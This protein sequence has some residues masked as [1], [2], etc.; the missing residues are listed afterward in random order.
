MRCDRYGLDYGKRFYKLFSK[1]ADPSAPVALVDGEILV[2]SNLADSH[3]INEDD[4]GEVFNNGI[5]AGRVQKRR[6]T[7]SHASIDSASLKRAK[8]SIDPALITLTA[9]IV[10]EDEKERNNIASDTLSQTKLI[11]S[12]EILHDP[13]TLTTN[14][15]P[16]LLPRLDES[17][18]RA[19]LLQDVNAVAQDRGTDKPKHTTGLQVR[20]LFADR[21]A[22]VRPV[23]Y[24]HLTLP[25]I[26]SV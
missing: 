14:C 22:Q 12:A 24:T 6:R 11:D 3:A 4:L 19:A 7:S 21:A 16:S 8:L 13:P 20:T 2:A 1:Y 15:P 9:P 26:Y 10:A 17:P 23:S 25:T 5:A 18:S